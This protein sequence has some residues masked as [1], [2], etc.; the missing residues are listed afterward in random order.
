[1]RRIGLTEADL[2]VEQVIQAGQ[3]GQIANGFGELGLID[4]NNGNDGALDRG[5][6]A[7][8]NNGGG[9]SRWR[10][11]VGVNGRRRR[12]SGNNCGRIRRS[13]SSSVLGQARETGSEQPEN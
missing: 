13:S 10:R 1:M 8:I 2:W 7:S 12:V 4:N 6:G 9:F 11:R 5:S 3:A